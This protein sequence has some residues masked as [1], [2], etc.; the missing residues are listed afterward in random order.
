MG[1]LLSAAYG[2]RYADTLKAL[3]RQAQVLVC[4]ARGLVERE[5]A[6]RAVVEKAAGFEAAAAKGKDAAITTGA[7][8]GAALMEPWAAQAAARR[9]AAGGAAADDSPS[10]TATAITISQLQ[11]AYVSLCR[12]KLLAPVAASEFGDLVDR[13]AAD[14][15]ITLCGSIGGKARTGGGGGTGSVGGSGASASSSSWLHMGL[16]MNVLMSDLDFAFADVPLYQSLAADIR[17]G[18]V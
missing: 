16:R 17:R 11:M 15:V 5:I 1:A 2:S 8:E 12:R 7:Y 14:G 3:P 13:L 9:G 18:R 4:A 6:R 10:L